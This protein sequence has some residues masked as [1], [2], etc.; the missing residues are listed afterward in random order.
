VTEVAT[1]RV[2]AHVET[3]VAVS[4]AAFAALQWKKR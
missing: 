2:G 3:C 4:D 1:L